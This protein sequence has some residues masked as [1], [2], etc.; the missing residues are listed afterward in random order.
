MHSHPAAVAIAYKQKGNE[1][2]Y[3]IT[4]AMRAKGMPEGEYDLGG[5]NVHVKGSEARLASGSLAGSIL[6]MNDGLENLKQ[7]TGA[8]LEELWRVTSLNQARALG[9]D[10]SKGSLVV[11][12]DADI[13]ITG[14]HTEVIATIKG[15]ELHEF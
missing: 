3:L 6:R 15:G 14:T 2:F 7:F 5:Q 11:G 9:V 13:V 4:D 8:N 1:H 10:S 12:K